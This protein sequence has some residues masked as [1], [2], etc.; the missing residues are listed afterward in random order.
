MP[1]KI[2]TPKAIHQSLAASFFCVLNVIAII[3]DIIKNSTINQHIPNVKFLI[4]GGNIFYFFYIKF[5][6]KFINK[7]NINFR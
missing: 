1:G 4:A 7:I 6:K 5:N 2:N 3:R